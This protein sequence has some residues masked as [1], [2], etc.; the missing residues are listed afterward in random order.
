V[1]EGTVE[2]H[3]AARVAF[4]RQAQQL[5]TAI[6]RSPQLELPEKPPFLVLPYISA[7][8]T[9]DD[10]Q[11]DPVWSNTDH[12]GKVIS[13]FRIVAGQPFGF[14]GEAYS[15][16]C[17]LAEKIQ[18]TPSL[19]ESV[20]FDT[21]LNETF[22]WACFSAAG[23]V[24][25]SA[26]TYIL[27]Q[28]AKLVKDV[29]VLVPVYELFLDEP[30]LIGKVQLRPLPEAEIDG[31][32]AAQ[33]LQYPDQKEAIKQS[34][35]RMKKELQGRAV[36]EISICAEKEQAGRIALQSA[37]D[38]TALLRLF[39]PA[40]FDPNVSS[41]CTT[42]GAQHVEKERWLTIEAG[43]LIGSTS[44]FKNLPLGTHWHVTA[45][46]VAFFRDHGLDDLGAIWTSDSRTDFEA[47]LLESF[48]LY[49]KATMT[50]NLADKLLY[51]IVALES[52]MLRNDTESIQSSI[53]ERLAFT[54]GRDGEERKQIARDVRNAYGL[55]SKFVH[56]GEVSD[57]VDTMRK[58]MGHVIH[59]L[60][61]LLANRTKFPTREAFF[62]A[63][64]TRKFA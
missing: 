41:A 20:A 28:C 42:L 3:P 52:F 12:T 17:K 48:M 21:V 16:L 44:R 40:S 46:M 34:T 50:H 13:R 33:E 4:D 64:E 25:S 54:I 43:E 53:A 22:D 32:S 23:T 55:R 6:E 8:I 58:F 27:E 5:L 30:L 10:I 26:T 51:V 9:A 62:D 60:V 31:W 35:L 24:T 49:S 57:D 11:G 63:M 56:H 18:K 59:G 61:T 47:K 2:I 14:E 7:T 38:A 19:R 36:A 29:V 39:S 15:Q 37:A 45:P 1:K